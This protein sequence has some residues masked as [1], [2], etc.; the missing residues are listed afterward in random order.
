M[1]AEGLDRIAGRYVVEASLA[2]GGMGIVYR[3]RD[4]SSGK[5]LALKRL[6]PGS[7]SAAALLFRREYHTLAR[8]RHPR[9][10][11]VYDYGLDA[12]GPF[13]TME[14]LDGQDLRA[15][16][17]LSPIEACRYLREV[18]SSL[19]LLH[20]H[21]LLHRDLTP[22]NVRITSDGRCKLIDFGALSPFGVSEA[23]LGTPPFVPPEAIHGLSLDQRADLFSLGALAYYLLTKKNAYPASS[24]R[25][26][27]AAWAKRPAAPSARLD[28]SQSAIPR[29]LDELVM[30]MLSL[31]PMARPRSAAEVI[32]RLSAIG[33]LE[34]EVE[35]GV[36][37]SY[38]LS[39]RMAGRSVE[40]ERSRALAESAVAGAGCVVA[41]EHDTGSGGTRL[42]T[43]MGLE[44]R[45]AGATVLQL[46]AEAYRGP[47]AIAKALAQKL[48]IALPDQT[49]AAATADVL[50]LGWLRA[51]ASERAGP[52]RA[53]VELA[54]AP[55]V[56]RLRAQSA[57]EKWFLD[58]ADAHPLSI[59]VDN[60]HRV[61]E[62]SAA[63]LALLAAA[64]PHHP[65]LLITTLRKGES[66][67]A[68]AALRHLL[69]D[70]ERFALGPLTLQDSS[71]LVRSLF[72][73]VPN[74]E[75]V[76]HWLY[77]LSS[78]YPHHLMELSRYLVAHGLARYSDGTW[79][80]PRELP[81]DAPSR[82]EDTLDERIG[83]LTP[84]A[85][86]LARAL[87]VHETPLSLELCAALAEAEHGDPFAA[88]D[89]L[90]AAG[91]LVGFGTGYQFEQE[92][93]RKRIF[94]R[95][96]E[97]ERKRL[98]R[99]LGVQLVAVS[100]PDLATTLSAGWHLYYG[101]DEKRGAEI[102]RGVALELVRID[103]LPEAVPALEAAVAV[104]GKLGHPRHQLLTLLEPLAFAGYYV[105]RRLASQ[106][107]DEALALLSHETGLTLTVRLRPYIG[108]Y[109]SLVVGLLYAILL[110]LFGGRGGLRVLNDRISILGGISCALT[111]TSA[112]CLDR[113]GAARRAAVFEPFSVMGKRHGGAFCHALA[114]SLV[115]LTEDR[116][117]QTIDEL[118]D[119]LVRLDTPWGVIGLPKPLRPILKGGI[120]FA[121]GALEGFTDP[122][123]AL[124]R[125]DALEGCGL[126]LYDMVASQIR[127]NYY[128]CQ[129]A[130]NSALEHEKQVEMH[131]VRSGS[132]WQAEAWAPSGKV[133]AC[134]VTSDLIGL[135]HAAEELE[136]MVGDIPSFS[137]IA[138]L[139]RVS[140]KA[141][142]GEYELAIPLLESTLAE[143]EAR[144][145]I[146]WGA[147]VGVLAW[148][149]NETGQH[150]RAAALC[151]QAL[152]Q[153]GESDRTVV[154]MNLQIE[155]QLA[156]AE[157]GL[158]RTEAALQR[159]DGLLA[160]H[161]VNGGHVT[162][163]SLHRARAQ[164]AL[165]V[166]DREALE[167]SYRQTEYW[168]R[169]TGNPALIAQSE[170]LAQL[171]LLSS[172]PPPP[173]KDDTMTVDLSPAQPSL[174]LAACSGPDERAR[175]VI[176][177]AVA[178]YRAE[179]GWLF[180]VRDGELTLLA[181]NGGQ[182]P[183]NEMATAVRARIVNM[184]EEQRTMTLE[185]GP[186]E[187]SL[188]GYTVIPLTLDPS[189]SD[190]EPRV[191]GAI[192][193]L[194]VQVHVAS[195]SDRF[196]RHFAKML[197]ESADVSTLRVL[198]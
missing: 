123:H 67:A 95:L 109:L 36:V 7:S 10:I 42:L 193:L 20:A 41:I 189:A 47:Y 58:I 127:A 32:D 82:F 159:L 197:Y 64:A 131:A 138:R 135:K 143:S 119:L 150:E 164:V 59:L 63:L 53:P 176:D 62:G 188:S 155:I 192:V 198:H 156:L 90:N 126:R 168:F 84:V 147:T 40:I 39:A 146:G 80:L 130:S 3:V 133:L 114:K 128:A 154:A 28:V 111:G 21:R 77:R 129:G 50:A 153:L 93:L 16:A 169:L 165:R 15:L 194:G 86:Q 141:L 70:A 162:L 145:Y 148:A 174:L 22:A 179:R 166:G 118:R 44:A 151:Q 180:G 112:I 121:L 13:Y 196:V 186:E 56:W 167:H 149:Y 55:G 24:F 91:I 115:R 48:A 134:I 11:Q 74:V 27:A 190:S 175:R 191:L 5:L 183:P 161:E 120:L 139:A 69:V 85:H 26:L 172:R 54:G 83:K 61:D 158:G 182:S 75:R 34:S 33:Q 116:A 72:G 140:L 132:A 92:A 12:E 99:L 163:G 108:S 117:A 4:E 6:L 104:F 103:D 144:S 19:S 51:P 68:P 2:S 97:E 177:F 38:L 31:D 73:E 181:T 187:D 124:Q 37:Q 79:A 100:A 171:L 125:A 102:L 45:I 17:P 106:Y 14:L 43:E 60:L 87:S 101:G 185:A 96:D 57:V 1:V 160:K 136:R 184:L 94:V 23:V 122:P 52:S 89:E 25:E 113:E 170:R 9:I 195:V 142:R 35:P 30:S 88:L 98:H 157:A 173:G 81:S 18:A 105:D 107:G 178:T 46:D 66:A 29:A 78:G 49:R 152:E 65:L 110:H 137:R 8:L 76:S 71:A